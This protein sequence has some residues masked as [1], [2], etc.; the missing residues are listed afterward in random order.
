MMQCVQMVLFFVSILFRILRTTL[1]T[2]TDDTDR[3]YSLS[4]STAILF[5]VYHALNINVFVRMQGV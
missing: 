4:S 3:S 1:S 5:K 2:F